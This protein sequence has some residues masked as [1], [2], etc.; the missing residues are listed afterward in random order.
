MNLFIL[1]IAALI[2]S[3]QVIKGQRVEVPVTGVASV[4]HIKDGVWFY[5]NSLYN[6]L[7]IVSDEGIIVIDGPASMAPDLCTLPS[8]I[9][10]IPVT[11]VIYSHPH[12]D[13]VGAVGCYE[14]DEDIIYIGHKDM[15]ESL[16]SS[17]FFDENNTPIPDILL[18][19]NQFCKKSNKRTHR[20]GLKYGSIT[21]NIGNQTIEI[22]KPFNYHSSSDLWILVNNVLMVVDSVFAPNYIPFQRFALSENV[23]NYRKALDLF[24]EDFEWD[25]M[26][27]GHW[28][29]SVT[30]EDIEMTIDYFDDMFNLMVEALS[31]ESV[32]STI[33]GQ[34]GGLS[35]LN[36]LSI[37]DDFIE[38]RVN[39]VNQ[40]MIEEGWSV[41]EGK[42]PNGFGSHG[43]L[44]NIEYMYFFVGI[45]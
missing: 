32:L 12:R 27:T 2:N 3:I 42:S 29:A 14:S 44:Q 21:L 35:G 16:E 33:I 24:L 1:L 4:A 7:F 22:Y 34:N 18:R 15:I 43:H 31:D 11:H 25:Y 39:Y 41:D 5:S 23:R 40:R 45:A 8:Q 20:S 30:R 6:G 38:N 36:T 13:H 9:S 28:H 19:D 26:V 10:N 37:L 17:R